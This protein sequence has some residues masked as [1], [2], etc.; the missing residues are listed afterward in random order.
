[1]LTI[2]I[3][4]ALLVSLTHVLCN[5]RNSKKMADL[6]TLNPCGEHYKVPL[7]HNVCWV[8]CWLIVIVVLGFFIFKLIKNLL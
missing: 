6:P 2:I 7:W 5:Y 1:M 8:G 3:L 4:T